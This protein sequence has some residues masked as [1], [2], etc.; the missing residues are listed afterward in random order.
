[1]LG[2]FGVRDLCTY[3]IIP[4]PKQMNKR[5]FTL[6]VLQNILILFPEALTPRN[7]GMLKYSF[8]YG[9]CLLGS[10]ELAEEDTDVPF[11]MKQSKIPSQ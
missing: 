6:K 4:S 3:L 1:M 7:L 9:L 11:L 2:A 10:V 8:R 5:E